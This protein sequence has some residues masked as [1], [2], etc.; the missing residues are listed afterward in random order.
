[1]VVID[2]ASTSRQEEQDQE[3]RNGEVEAA[4]DDGTL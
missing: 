2:C 4:E 3:V 1:M